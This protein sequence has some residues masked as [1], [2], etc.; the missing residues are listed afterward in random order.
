[1]DTFVASCKTTEGALELA[2]FMERMFPLDPKS[3]LSEAEQLHKFNVVVGADNAIE[4]HSTVPVNDLGRQDFKKFVVEFTTLMMRK[5]VQSANV[6][7]AKSRR[8]A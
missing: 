3:V 1:M 8:A 4:V 5:P 6:N 2:R 7:L